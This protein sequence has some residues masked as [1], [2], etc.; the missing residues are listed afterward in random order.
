ML[1]KRQIINYKNN[2]L[3]VVAGGTTMLFEIDTSNIP[4]VI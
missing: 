4:E 3:H 1:K 2:N